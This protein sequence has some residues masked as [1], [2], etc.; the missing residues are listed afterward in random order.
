M[1]GRRRLQSLLQW[2]HRP[3]PIA[4]FLRAVP[5][6]WSS[7]RCA[8]TVLNDIPVLADEYAVRIADLASVFPAGL[9]AAASWDRDLMYA[10]GA[11]MGMEFRTKGAHIML[12]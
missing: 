7:G 1:H 3:N 2:Q 11:A 4:E 9:T 5:P 6:R 8:H 10:R 12:G